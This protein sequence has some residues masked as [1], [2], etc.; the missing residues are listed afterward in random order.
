MLIQ[1][2]FQN[3]LSV[4]SSKDEALTALVHLGYLGYDRDE[5]SAYIPNYEVK[6]AYQA[7][8]NTGCWSEVAKINCK[9]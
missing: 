5:E 4:V 2:T 6:M 1:N 8:L 9:M 3:D 7:A